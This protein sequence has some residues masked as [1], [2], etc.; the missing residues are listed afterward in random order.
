MMEL[1][2]LG[3]L[4]CGN[5]G[6]AVARGVVG[7]KLLPAGKV[8][9]FDPEPAVI[10]S[11]GYKSVDSWLE[12]FQSADVIVLAVKPQVFQ[13]LA[14]EWKEAFA[15][16]HLVRKTIISV[17]AGIRVMQMR[18]IFP[19]SFSVIRV[20]PNLCL[21]V[22]EGA[23]AIASD[24]LSEENL[25]LVEKIFQA[26]G[27]TVRVSEKHMDAVTGVSGSGPMYV[28]EFVEAWTEAGER[29]GLSR[30]TS[31]SLAIQTIKGALKLL[32]SSGE[33]PSTWS[34]RVRSPGGTTAEAQKVL[35]RNKFQETLIRAIEAA[36]K[37]SKEL[38]G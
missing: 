5:M 36:A 38:S 12:L 1:K 33:E 13:K 6:S 10:Q 31:Y 14:V 7:A 23:T 30:E 11:P 29:C 15:S 28:F 25:A 8:F 34:E 35:D 24:G 9:V 20:M 3:L 22:G 37:R 19:D 21:S 4:G 18:D 2:N 26:S 16:S 32:E 27:Q 17:M